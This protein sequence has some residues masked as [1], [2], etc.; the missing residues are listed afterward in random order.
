MKKFMVILLAVMFVVGGC[1]G[2]G[3]FSTGGQAIVDFVCS[4]D[5]AQKAEAAKWLAA[6][7]SIQAGV[8]VAFPVLAI[9]KA[10]TAMTVLKN[11]GCF[12]LAEV[13]AALNLLGAM[14]AE[15]VKAL[16]VKT[17]PR[18][19]ESQFPVLWATVKEQRG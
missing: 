5:D 1:T 3:K 14:Q 7:D 6:L 13:E 8:S 9:V 19:I 18:S 11:G 2:L 17:A 4:P 15:Q 10:S 12:I 16:R